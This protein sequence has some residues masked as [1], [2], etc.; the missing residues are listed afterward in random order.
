MDRIWYYS[1]GG[2]ENFGPYTE[3][4]LIRLLQKHIL[5]ENDYIWMSRLD[6]WIR[7]GDSIYS[8][9]LDEPEA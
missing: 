1:K 8:F 4:D 9:Y 3:E 2:E 6:D 7:I 5:N